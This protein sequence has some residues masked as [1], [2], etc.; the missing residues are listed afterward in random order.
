MRRKRRLRSFDPVL[1]SPTALCGPP[2]F[3]PLWFQI[4]GTTSSACCRKVK[5]GT[6][7]LTGDEALIKGAP[8][9]EEIELIYAAA[10]EEKW[11]ES[12]AAANAWIRAARDAA[13]RRV[14]GE[15]FEC[16]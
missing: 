7:G 14:A 3:R 10:P 9:C 4:L 13:R 11:N 12:P 2:A 15:D 16:E 8:L 6:C 5:T 1:S